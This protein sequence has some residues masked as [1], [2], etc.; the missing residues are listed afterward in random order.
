MT[1]V[2]ETDS[3]LLP[4]DVKDNVAGRLKEAS[5]V[6][7]LELELK[8]DAMDGAKPFAENLAVLRK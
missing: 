7:S 4:Q 6:R 2:I 8:G 5:D 1:D 3:F